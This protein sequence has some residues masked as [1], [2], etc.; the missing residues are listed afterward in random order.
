MRFAGTCSRYSNSAIPQLTM[1][2]TYHGRALRF[3]R[4]AYHA[5]VMKTF[6][7]MRRTVVR[8][9][10]DERKAG[11]RR[12]VVATDTR[13]DTRTGTRIRGIPSSRGAEVGSHVIDLLRLRDLWAG[14]PAEHPAPQRPLRPHR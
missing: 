11:I 9:M 13:T 10:V 12:S 7:Q 8:T 4:C 6:E 1:A 3:R 14:G 2:A 5:N